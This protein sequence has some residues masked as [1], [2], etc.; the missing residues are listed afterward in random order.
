MLEKKNFQCN[1]EVQ[2]NSIMSSQLS[3]IIKFA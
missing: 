3:R 2:F 1:N